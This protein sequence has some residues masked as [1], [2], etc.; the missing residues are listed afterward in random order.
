MGTG[1]TISNCINK[2][3]IEASSKGGGICGWSLN[4]SDSILNCINLGK[5]TGSGTS[6]TL[7]AIVATNSGNVKNT[8][9]LIGTAAQA[10]DGSSVASDVA[11][12]FDT[13]LKTT[14]TLT[15]EG[16][17]SNNLID[18]L[19]A[20]VDANN[21]SGAEQYLKWKIVDGKPALVY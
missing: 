4:S 21:N 5:V 7:G 11:A 9:Y 18:L 13:N 20:W 19:N 14:N 6:T 8:Y 10:I 2:G 1:A 17:K 12:Q 16:T 3:D 15:V